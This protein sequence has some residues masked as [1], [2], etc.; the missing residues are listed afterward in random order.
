MGDMGEIFKAMNE[1]KKQRHS[2]GFGKNMR[3]LEGMR[4]VFKE[5]VC[6]FRETG[7]PKIDFY[8]HTGRWKSKNKIH[9]GGAISF[10]NWY[11]KQ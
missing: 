1:D 7:K 3:L 10:I 6:L 2:D 9:R 5:T 11:S 4:F 8:P